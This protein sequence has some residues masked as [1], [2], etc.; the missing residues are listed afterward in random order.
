MNKLEH[1]NLMTQLQL[2]NE[3]VNAD[4][5]ILFNLS[6]IARGLFEKI[7]KPKMFNI[8]KNQKEVTL[9]TEEFTE[10]RLFLLRLGEASKGGVEFDNIEGLIKKYNDKKV[11]NQKILSMLTRP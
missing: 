10:L 9:T 3:I 11:N 2:L 8:E 7:I 5:M 6:V 1:N 4:H